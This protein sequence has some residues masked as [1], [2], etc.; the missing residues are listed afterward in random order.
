[1]TTK[2]CLLAYKI[3]I[4]R[5]DD[6]KILIFIRSGLYL[7]VLGDPQYN[8]KSILVKMTVRF[9]IIEILNSIFVVDSL[10]S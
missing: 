4:D 2:V 5:D 10:G 3:N 6:S 9:K 7:T 8:K 1:M